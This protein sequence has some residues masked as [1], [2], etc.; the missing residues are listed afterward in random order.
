MKVEQCP[1]CGTIIPA[2]SDVCPICGYTLKKKTT[3]NSWRGIFASI[4]ARR[5]ILTMV[6]VFIFEI[7][8]MFVITAIPMSFSQAKAIAGQTEPS[9]QAVRSL[10]ILSRSVSIFSHNYE[11]A[12]IEIVPVIGQIFFVI[13]TY[14]TAIVLDAL[15]IGQGVP[16]PIALFTLLLL[17][18]SWLELPSYAIAATEGGFLI[19][20]IFRKQFRVEIKRAV[21]VWLLVGI[22]LLT[23]GIFESWTIYLETS[24]NPF[25]IFITWIP[26]VII[27]AIFITVVRSFLKR[28]ES[29]KSRERQQY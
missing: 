5:R 11:I 22:E 18:Y 13:S 1:Q 21:I 19:A 9:L 20:S 7:A 6:L 12:S 28:Y 25:A 10:P 29:S 17:P 24:S 8:L 16:G 3:D 26:Y 27:L 15:A 4:F 2:G 14:S 23:A